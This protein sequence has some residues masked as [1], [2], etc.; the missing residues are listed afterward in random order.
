MFGWKIIKD[1][2]KETYVFLKNTMYKWVTD[3]YKK[4]NSL[5]FDN[6]LPDPD[7]EMIIF[8]ITTDKRYKSLGTAY[9]RKPYMIRINFRYDLPEIEY[10]DT[11]LHEMIHIWQY[12]IGYK[13][14][15]GKSFKKKAREINKYGWNITDK[16]TNKLIEIKDVK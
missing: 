5:Y 2:D 4:F 11:L 1:D 6:L 9:D 14:S 13:G 7:G 10:Q 8:D 12:V 16:Y 15:H 3:N